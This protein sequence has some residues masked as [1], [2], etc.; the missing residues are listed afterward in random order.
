MFLGVEQL[1]L[2]TSLMKLAF[3]LESWD[4]CGGDRELSGQ[5]ALREGNQH[6]DAAIKIFKEVCNDLLDV[7]L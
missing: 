7:I 6:I 2:G 3:S 5:E 4:A 1:K